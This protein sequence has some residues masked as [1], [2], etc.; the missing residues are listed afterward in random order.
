M[1]SSVVSQDSNSVLILKN[2]SSKKEKGRLNQFIK[3]A[4]SNPKQLSLNTHAAEQH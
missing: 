3:K 4:K 1:P 2:K